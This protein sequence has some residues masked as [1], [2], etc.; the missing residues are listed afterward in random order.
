MTEQEL[1]TGCKQGDSNAQKAVYLKYSS[2]VLGIAWRYSSSK[3]E[4]E[5]IL[6]ESF[7]KVFTKID[8]F[9]GLGS[10]E[11]WIKRIVI[12]TA[13]NIL[14]KKNRHLK[15]LNDTPFKEEESTNDAI[16]FLSSQEIM[17][18]INQ[19]SEGYRVILNLYAIEGYTHKEI[20]DLLGIAESTSKSQYSRARKNLLGILSRKKGINAVAI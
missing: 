11:G 4:A 6:Q 17:E 10:F 18:C 3:E 15:F 8:T 20:G 1:V 16:D 12:T 9:L 5:D 13:I 7:I 19:L 14:K 2:I